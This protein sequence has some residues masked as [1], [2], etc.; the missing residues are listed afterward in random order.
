[1]APLSNKINIIAIF[2]FILA[3]NCLDLSLLASAQIK[4]DENMRVSNALVIL[5]CKSIDEFNSTRIELESLGIKAYHRFP[6]ESFIG[7]VHSAIEGEM[8]KIIA[9]IKIIKSNNSS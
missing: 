8:N 4:H 9:C 5:D 3:F 1:M 2:A 6:P 7:Y